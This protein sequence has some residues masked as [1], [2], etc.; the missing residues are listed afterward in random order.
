MNLKLSTL[1][2]A[3]VTAMAIN[4]QP[5]EDYSCDSAVVTK[6]LDTNRIV[7]SIHPGEAVTEVRN[8]R[9]VKLDLSGYTSRC[10]PSIIGKLTALEY[11]RMGRL[12]SGRKTAA[13]RWRILRHTAAR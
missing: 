9:I 10:M 13:L 6:I 5:C 8:G 12:E 11:L 1:L 3:S 7:P 2:L 4:A